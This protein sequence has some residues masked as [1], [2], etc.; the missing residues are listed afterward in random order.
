MRSTI[1][2]SDEI[3]TS[4]HWITHRQSMTFIPKSQ[5]IEKRFLL[6]VLKLQ[7]PF[8]AAVYRS[9]DTRVFARP[10][11]QQISHLRAKSFNVAEVQLF[12]TRHV[13]NPPGRSAI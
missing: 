10:D 2:R 3:E 4:A 9:V 6:G 8:V 13:P 11:A 7:R 5:G 1:V 12:R